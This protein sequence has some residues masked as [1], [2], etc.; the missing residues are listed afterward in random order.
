M[1]PILPAAKLQLIMDLLDENEYDEDGNIVG[2]KEPIIS[3]E[4]ALK[5]LGLVDEDQQ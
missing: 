3:K 2:Q 5:I 4:E 1:L